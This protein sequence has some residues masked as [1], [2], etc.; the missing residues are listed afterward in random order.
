MGE[1][2]R[3]IDTGGVDWRRRFMPPCLCLF[4]HTTMIPHLLVAAYGRRVRLKAEA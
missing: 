1:V 3:F 2:G 4:T